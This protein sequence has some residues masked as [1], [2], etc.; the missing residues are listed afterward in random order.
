MYT[1]IS[2]LLLILVLAACS[3]LRLD[4]DYVPPPAASSEKY[5][6]DTHYREVKDEFGP[7]GNDIVV[8]EFFAYGCPHCQTF[9]TYI[10][11][12]GKTVPSDVTIKQSPVVWNEVMVLQA[13]LF[14]I[15]SS[16]EEFAEIHEKLFI[17]TAAIGGEKDLDGQKKHYAKLFAEYGMEEDQFM[18][19]LSA[20][21][22][23]LQVEDAVQLMKSSGLSG[24]PA[25]V[26][27]GKYLIVT[28]SVGSQGEI[29][30]IADF[31]IDK[32]RKEGR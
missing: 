11:R 2:L 13:K 16:M 12:W 23:K 24:T 14:F 32:E 31:L 3:E 7:E 9:Q 20:S 17:E 5:L 1:K 21:K 30:D 19:Q 29:L 6:L 22:V 15:A 10:D 27:N 25:I 28:S 4:Q 18:V 8:T 26:V